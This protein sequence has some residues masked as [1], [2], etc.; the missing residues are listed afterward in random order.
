MGLDMYLTKYI[1]VKN[2]DHMKPEEKHRVI[3][4]KGGHIRR[5]IKPERISYVIEEVGYWRKANQIHAWFV[6][7]CQDGAD[8]SRLAYVAHKQLKELYSTC[9]KVWKSIELVDGQIKNGYSYKDGE[10]VPIMEPGKII[11][12]PKT[13]QELLPTTSGFFFGSTEYD[14]WYAEDIKNTI[15]ILRG[16]M[17]DE[18]GS[19]YYQSS[20]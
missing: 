16:V 1:Y 19:Y 13:A 6:E 8:D 5:D 18:S 15:E 2:W 4:K 11:K 7:N 9:K 12:D 10:K 20:W 14:Q 3:V 17:L